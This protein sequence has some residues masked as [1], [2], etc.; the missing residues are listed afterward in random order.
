MTANSITAKFCLARIG[1]KSGSYFLP[2][3]KAGSKNL[4][5]ESASPSNQHLGPL[6]GYYSISAAVVTI[7]PSMKDVFHMP[8]H[9]TRKR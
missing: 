2:V 8:A 9:A 1:L 3:P 5:G 4:R 7:A 6:N